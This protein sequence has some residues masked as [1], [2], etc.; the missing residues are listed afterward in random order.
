MHQDLR[1]IGGALLS[2]HSF[3]DLITMDDLKTAVRVNAALEAAHF[4]PHAQQLTALADVAVPKPP[5]EKTRV[6]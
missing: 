6:D 5:R 4:S 2:S 3:P 1:G